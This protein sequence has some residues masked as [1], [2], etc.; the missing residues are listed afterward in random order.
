M[1]VCV[2]VCETR[3]RNAIDL[4]AFGKEVKKNTSRT[5][6][7]AQSKKCPLP[8]AGVRKSRLTPVLS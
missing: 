1:A 3:M 5:T 6:A 8:T 4:S 2:C 7:N